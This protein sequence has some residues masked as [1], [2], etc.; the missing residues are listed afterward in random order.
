[1]S[2]SRRPLLG[3]PLRVAPPPPTQGTATT[4][5]GHD[6]PGEGLPPADAGR[7]PGGS[8]RLTAR[9][10]RPLSL[11]TRL[12]GVL[13]LLLILGTVIIG[14]ATHATMSA[15][16]NAQLND[17]LRSA[18]DRAGAQIQNKLSQQSQPTPTGLPVGT[19][20]GLS[21][22]GNYLVRPFYLDPQSTSSS[23]V[24]VSDAD[25]AT[26]L[27]LANSSAPDASPQD[28]E[29]SIGSYRVQTVALTS[30]QSGVSATMLV[31][32]P[33][34][35][36][37]RT[38][39]A[40]DVSMV[41]IGVGGLVLIGTLGSVLISRSL[42]PL[43]RVSSVASTVA[44]QPLERGNVDVALRVAPQ[45]SQPG[46][47]VGNVGH[48]LNNLLDNVDAALDVRAASEKQ[49]RSF[50]ADASHEL[51]TPL[52]AI[53]GYSELL[54]A[55]EALSEDG[56]RSLD[57]VREQTRRMTALVEDLLLLAR[58]DERRGR[59]SEPVDLARLARDLTSDFAVA[60]PDHVWSF[61]PGA[62]GP[63][64]VE[65]DE[66]QLHRVL[67]NLMSNARKHTSEGTRVTVSLG[68]ERGTT[69]VLTVRDDGEG[70]DEQFLGRI[71]DRFTRADT[72]RSGSAPTTGLGLSIVK[73]IVE[74]HHGEISVRSVP[75]DTA[76]EVRLP[77]AAPAQ[78][79]PTAP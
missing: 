68:V 74:S 13:L 35:Q 41:L 24:T 8:R 66:G 79:G 19:V 63:V 54:D 65:G 27:A 4:A 38:L 46:T 15:R 29:L 55:T 12:V 33:T 42:R 32:I 52:A 50:A 7:S 48:A 21:S 20:T 61:A 23:T 49:M 78:E 25:A 51:R 36:A 3:R 60:A 67:Q 43:A 53:Q 56:E 28:V 44:Q 26:L 47:E 37:T 72:A 45:D 1:M 2:R 59:A 31:A 69:A 73:A 22:E 6:H 58:L 70:I 11:R 57:R 39:T 9:L 71:F 76:F 64:V 14:G 30:R 34:A 17:D 10:R 16:L 5:P 62:A 75:G 18:S 40:L 77:L